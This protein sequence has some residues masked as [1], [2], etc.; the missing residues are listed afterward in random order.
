MPEMSGVACIEEILSF[1]PAANIEVFSGY[2]QDVIENLSP[3]A[4]A[5]IKDFIP[6]PV[7]LEDLSALLAKMLEKGKNA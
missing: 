7:G 1:D 3:D 6:K 5:A 2:N 4:R